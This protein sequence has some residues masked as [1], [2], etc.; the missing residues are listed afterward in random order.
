MEQQLQSLDDEINNCQKQLERLQK[1][2]KYQQNI[3][4]MRRRFWLEYKAQTTDDAD[5]YRL[6][7]SVFCL[8]FYIFCNFSIV[9]FTSNRT[10]GY[11][12]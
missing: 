1:K 2:Q 11:S 7:L 3:R 8:Y 4:A 5:I 6:G 10:I 12:W 9:S